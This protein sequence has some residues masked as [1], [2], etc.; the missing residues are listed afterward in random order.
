M[1]DLKPETRAFLS[2][3]REG[4]EPSEQAIEKNRR[5]LALKL[6]GASGAAGS[7][8]GFSS[9]AAAAGA[10]GWGAGKMLIVCGVLVVGAGSMFAVGGQERSDMPRPGSLVE[11]PAKSASVAPRDLS[12]EKV[13]EAPP[14]VRAEEDVVDAPLD[15]REEEPRATEAPLERREEKLRATEAPPVEP[16]SQPS[17]ATSLQAEFD[18]VRG[19]QNHLH[20]NEPA[21]ALALLQQHASRFPGGALAEERRASLVVAL[22]QAGNVEEARRRAKRFVLQSPSSPFVE[23]VR[24]ACP[25]D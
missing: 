15:R 2:L 17:K 10:S 21:A 6:A 7:A 3:A 14:P 25:A 11:E 12:V 16:R 8:I 19:A 9:Q 22:C 4:D 18:L 23:R 13:D 20:R 24:N 5:S 1:N